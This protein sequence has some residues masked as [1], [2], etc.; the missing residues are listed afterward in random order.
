MTTSFQR[1]PPE[2]ADVKTAGVGPKSRLGRLFR[3]RSGATAPLTASLVVLALLYAG[4]LFVL[5]P[6]H[7]GR[8][9]AL[10]QVLNAALERRVRNARFL[11]EDKRITGTMVP[12]AGGKPVT[13]YTAYPSSDVATGDILRA[14]FT[15]GAQVN[16]DSQ[17]TKRL[18]RF[19]AQFLLPLVILANLFALLFSLGRGEG[20]GGA[21]KD[22]LV[23]GKIGNKLLGAAERGRA[24]F[25]DVAAAEEAVVE[26]REVVEYLRFV[27]KL[28]GIPSNEI[29][30]RVD[31]VMKRCAVHDVRQQHR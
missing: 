13:F 8:P 20:A 30:S 10:N 31:D 5:R 17:P 26:L 2:A 6:A 23:F 29:T 22:F 24:S 25:A 1:Q 15:S 19:L 3:L 9:V 4:A 18:I 16:V 11:D 12:P 28:K 21:T 27:G 14:F 7:P